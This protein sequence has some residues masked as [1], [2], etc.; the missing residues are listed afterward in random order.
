MMLGGEPFH[1]SLAMEWFSCIPN[2]RLFNISGPTEICMACMGLEVLRS[3]I[4]PAHNNILAFGYPWKNTKAIVVDSNNQQVKKGETGFLSFAGDHVMKGYFNLKNTSDNS[5]FN[6]EYQGLIHRFYNSGDR[7]LVNDKGVYFTLGRTD[8]Q[9]KVRGYKIELAEIEVQALKIVNSCRVIAL[10]YM[11]ENSLQEIALFIET[12]NLNKDELRQKL[13]QILPEYMLPSVVI[14][15]EEFPTLP[16]NKI[17]R[18]KLL[19]YVK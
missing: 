12:S 9:V 17:D 14:R 1:E 2:S 3:C 18:I 19:D 10:P 5:I 13:S 6:I 4:N 11:S 16:N 15:I 7:V 8:Q